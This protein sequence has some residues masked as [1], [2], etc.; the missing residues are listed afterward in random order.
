MDFAEKRERLVKRLIE[1]GILKKPEVIRAML[2]VP[3]EEFVP[4]ELR[5]HAYI[6]SPLPT[7]EGQRSSALRVSA[8]VMFTP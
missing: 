1:E 5:E 8:G 3:R 7:L 4:P 6:D 2:R